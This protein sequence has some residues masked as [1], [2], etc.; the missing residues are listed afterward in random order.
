MKTK[1]SLF[2]LS[3]SLLSSHAQLVSEPV[4]GDA[5]SVGPGTA[6][7]EF[8]VGS[9]PLTIQ[10]LGVYG[11]STEG[12]QNSHL[13][14]LWDTSTPSPS[15]LASTTVEPNTAVNRNGY[16]Y[17][18]IT[19]LTLQSGKSYVLGALY[20]DVDQ[21]LAQGSASATLAGATY[22]GARLSS[23]TAF[24]F[25]DLLIE[26]VDKGFFGPNAGFTAV[27]EPETTAI[28]TSLCLLVLVVGYRVR[29]KR[30]L[31]GSI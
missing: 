23:S 7:F 21:D 5:L 27:P 29:F 9:E 12:L 2:V 19:P 31:S 8:T 4:G 1:L 26:G 17:A 20:Q 16:W 24:S 15:L 3:L 28:V 30:E 25:P 6:G 14:G 10:S 18:G 13:I 22:I 11:A